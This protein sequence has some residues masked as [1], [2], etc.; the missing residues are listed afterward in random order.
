MPVALLLQQGIASAA[1]AIP[2]FRGQDIE[3]EPAVIAPI[4]PLLASRLGRAEAAGLS[5][6]EAEGA[7][8]IEIP[9]R[10]PE[11]IPEGLE[12]AAAS[13]R[14][15]AEILPGGDGPLL[16]LE[17]PR[18]RSTMEALIVRAGDQLAALP[19]D[20]TIE[21]LRPDPVDLVSIGG[22]AQLMRFRGSYLPVIGLCAAL[23]EAAPETADDAIVVVMQSAGGDFGIRVREVTD[24]RQ[25]MVKPVGNG[26]STAAGVIGF[27]FSAGGIALVLDIDTLRSAAI[28]G[29]SGA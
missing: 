9:W 29:G 19:V 18:S 23:G 22:D 6:S 27:S 16:R 17:L 2:A 8:L 4:L 11:E 26:L 21:I 3:I 10:T 15:R 12:A 7:V 24:H 5:V 20:R 14:G 25:I 1:A 13:V 28:G